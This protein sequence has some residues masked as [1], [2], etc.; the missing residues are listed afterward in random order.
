MI[1]GR[2]A[3]AT[4]VLGA[5]EGWDPEKDG[6]CGGLAIADVDGVMI[7]AWMPLPDELEKLA[8]G[9]PI[10]LQVVGTGHPPVMLFVGEP[11]A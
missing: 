1:P 2:I 5:P 6:D 3:N 7:S 4:R 9:A 10:Y 8:A 11:P